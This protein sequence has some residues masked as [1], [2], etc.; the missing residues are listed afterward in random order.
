[1][2]NAILALNAGSSSIKFAVY[3]A[4]D[5]VEGSLI[6]KGVLETHARGARFTIKDATGHVIDDERP[7]PGSADLTLA[8]LD[9]IEPLLGDC[10]LSAVGHRIVHGGPRF[11]D[12]TVIEG[13]VLKAL[14]EL[15]PLAPLH[16]PGCL[17]PVRSLSHARPGL[18]QVACFDTAFHRDLQPIYQRFPIP[19]FGEG[20]HRYGFH[21]LSFE[22]IAH[23]LDEPR[24]RTVIAHLGSGSSVC[25]L[26]HGKSVNTTM[27]LT[28]LD[29]LM[30][31]T[32]CGAIDPG[33]LLYLQRAKGLSVDDIEHLLYHKS[34]LLG[35]AGVSAD[36]RT[37]LAASDP[38]AKQAVEQ[39]CARC[40]EF[41]AVMATSLGGFERL[42]FTGGVGENSPAVRSNICERLQWLGIELDS[43]AN[44]QG[45]D[46]ISATKSRIT[47]RV[48]PT[49][50]EAMI[51]KHT[52]PL[53][54]A[55]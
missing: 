9:R 30:M 4:G 27:S 50:E 54:M 43:S 29:G 42:V 23:R 14:D 17:A 37:L 7:A 12:P 5:D 21:G 46:T 31:A 24:L 3:R 32:R 34:G 22:Y 47:V 2:T 8:L 6:C 35:V 33:L 15:T 25:A 19:D 38:G 10:E 48:I 49:N 44:H 36:M 26:H 11:F 28:P 40:A 20:I 41:V 51:A 39:F 45:S 55:G 1:M 16:Q 13:D 18:L 53:I 52:I